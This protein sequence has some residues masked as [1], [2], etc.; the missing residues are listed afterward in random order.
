MLHLFFKE[1]ARYF[2][3]KD[4]KFLLN[5]CVKDRQLLFSCI[6]GG[7]RRDRGN[8]HQQISNKC[9]QF[10]IQPLFLS[11]VIST[12]F[13]LVAT[14]HCFMSQALWNLDKSSDS[15]SLISVYSLGL[16]PKPHLYFSK[17][18]N[19]FK[20]GSAFFFIPGFLN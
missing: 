16:F 3:R 11:F 19:S 2:T 5:Q 14:D 9:V 18:Y 7:E 20:R 4:Y 10:Q 15:C 1:T 8:F 13:P 17:T 6:W 12:I